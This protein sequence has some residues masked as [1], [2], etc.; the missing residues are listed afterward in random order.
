MNDDFFF[1]KSPIPQKVTNHHEPKPIVKQIAKS[2]MQ[3]IFS[4]ELFKEYKMNISYNPKEYK[5]SWMS[6]DNK[7]YK[8]K[9]AHY[10]RNQME[11]IEMRTYKDFFLNEDYIKRQSS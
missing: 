2:D 1:I 7:N 5:S 4:L 10:L 9:Q 3:M 11:I 6:M 8:Y